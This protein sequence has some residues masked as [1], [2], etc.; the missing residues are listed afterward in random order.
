MKQ[1]NTENWQSVLI[2]SEVRGNVTAFGILPWLTMMVYFA[3][4]DP[5]MHATLVSERRSLR[6]AC[7]ELIILSK[8]LLTYSFCSFSFSPLSL[9]L[10]LRVIGCSS[11]NVENITEHSLQLAASAEVTVSHEWSCSYLYMI[12]VTMQLGYQSFLNRLAALFLMFV[13]RRMCYHAFCRSLSF[14]PL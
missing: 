8:Q 12:Y 5:T 9:L 11:Q 13:R 1:Q 7:L 6:S 10:S 3:R 2:I 14:F 4:C